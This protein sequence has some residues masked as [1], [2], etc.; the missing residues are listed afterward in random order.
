MNKKLVIIFLFLVFIG[1]GAW[2]VRGFLLSK[3]AG[4]AELRIK[5]RPTASIFL[6]NENL[7]RTPY[8]EKIKPGEYELKLIPEDTD[9]FSSWQQRIELEPAT[10]TYVNVELGDSEISSAWEILSLKKTGR[11]EVEIA[12]FSKTD[13][14]EVFIDGERKGTTPLSFQDISPGEHELKLSAPSFLERSIK[15]KV[16]A[17]YKLTVNSQLSLLGEPSKEE[18]TEGEKKETEEI[19][20]PYVLIKETPT[21]WL[22]VRGEPSTTSEELVKINPGEKYPLLDE[23]E[24]WYK[25]KYEKDKEGWISGRYA[26]KF[27]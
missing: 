9:A 23:S 26:E 16:T 17:G 6:E 22:R 1:A 4:K 27:E 10:Q 8:Q 11:K 3:T 2:L 13:S 20:E 24:G 21:G 25:I 12:V 19:E 15:I 14:S 18:K 5:S 7:G